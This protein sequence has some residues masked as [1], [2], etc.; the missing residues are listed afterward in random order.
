M[1]NKTLQAEQAKKAVYT[2]PSLTELNNQ[3]TAGGSGMT[4][5][6]MAMTAPNRKGTSGS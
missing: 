1:I 5:E 6:A 4:A 2:K 3:D